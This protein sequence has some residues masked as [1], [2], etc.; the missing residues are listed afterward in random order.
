MRWIMAPARSGGAGERGV[1]GRPAGTLSDGKEVA[2]KTYTPMIG[3]ERQYVPDFQRLHQH[4]NIVQILGY[5]IDTKME[6]ISDKPTR[7]SAE[8]RDNILVV[9]EYMPNGSLHNILRGR[10]LARRE[11]DWTTVFRIIRG[12]A[13]GMAFIHAQRFI[14]LYWS[15][16]N[17]L[18][19]SDMNPKFSSFGFS[20]Q[21]EH[22]DQEVTQEVTEELV[23]L[24]LTS[25]GRSTFLILPCLSCVVLPVT[26]LI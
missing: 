4:E 26:H 8:I 1:A 10:G 17:I 18:F 13:R 3:S 2:I 22:E 19:D 12:I 23:S 5:C 11:L 21:L 20:K 7:S 25:S 9:E 15:T 16:T 14:Y 6:T 24:T